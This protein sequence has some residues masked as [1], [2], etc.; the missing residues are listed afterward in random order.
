MNKTIVRISCNFC[1]EMIAEYPFPVTKKKA[2]EEVEDWGGLVFG[3]RHFC[4]AI[5][6]KEFCKEGKIK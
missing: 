4:G 2:D 5:C 6:Y 1:E 3:K